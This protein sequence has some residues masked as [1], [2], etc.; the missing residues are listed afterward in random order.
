MKG[1]CV[2]E[3]SAT[4][5]MCAL[6]RCHWRE[7]KGYIGTQRWMRKKRPVSRSSIRALRTMSARPQVGRGTSRASSPS[8][9]LYFWNG[10]LLISKDAPWAIGITG[11][12]LIA[13]PACWIAFEA[14]YLSQGV[15][16]APVVLFVY[17]WINSVASMLKTALTDPGILPRELDPEPDWQEPPSPHMPL[18]IEGPMSRPKDRSIALERV[19]DGG[20]PSLGTIASIPSVWCETCHVYRPPR[21]S[22]CRSCNNCVDTL[23]HHCILL[24]A[25]IGRRNYTTFYAFLCHTMAMLLVGIVGCILK[26]YY[27]AAPTT[28]AQVRADG[29]K[30]TRGFVHALKKTPESAVFFFLATVWSI[31]VVCLWTYHTWLL[32][33]NRTTVEQIRLESTS[34]LYDVH[35]PYSTE[36]FDSGACVRGM[37]AC[38]AKIRNVVVPKEFATPLTAFEPPSLSR[39][40]T[41]QMR[42]TRAPFQHKN[43]SR[44]ALQVLGRPTFT[45]FA[46]VR[47]HGLVLTSFP[48]T[49]LPVHE[50]PN[51][52]VPASPL[53]APPNAKIS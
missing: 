51:E 39:N 49:S 31:P 48:S 24:N 35:R 52:S 29:N 45:S 18:D 32:H 7:R 53:Y 3:A 28:V 5:S 19:D 33:Q 26:L 36:L 43:P 17:F 25:C 12:L 10:R 9:T 6:E 16:V 8:N 46:L 14:P 11:T 4:T 2:E 13:G 50:L 20:D 27:I 42:R 47:P 1:V 38:S 40:R 41:R 22:H 34:R 44:N 30:T 15:S 23:D 37:A 21:C